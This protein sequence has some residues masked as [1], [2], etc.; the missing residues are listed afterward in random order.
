MRVVAEVIR[1]SF[2]VHLL[3]AQPLT[4]GI[5]VHRC[6]RPTQGPQQGEVRDA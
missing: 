5:H 3:A 2:S 6:S 1:R 4:Q